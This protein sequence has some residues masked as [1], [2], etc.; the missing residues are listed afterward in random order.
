MTAKIEKNELVIRIPMNSTPEPSK[1]GN[2]LMVASTGGFA[3][4]EATVNGKTVKVSVNAII[5]P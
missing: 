3:P 4:T 5:K 1:S 2:S